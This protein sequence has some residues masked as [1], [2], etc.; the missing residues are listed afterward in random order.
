M[1]WAE[2]R[3]VTLQ[4]RELL[5]IPYL[6]EA[7]AVETEPGQWLIRL[8][9]PELPG[10]TAEGAVVEDALRD[11]ERRRVEIIV[12]LVERDQQPPIPR[13]PLAASD[14]LWTVHELG[15]SDRVTPLLANENS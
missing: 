11:L 7:E 10:C 14:P 8:A 1:P 4:L 3:E 6:L 5:A 2:N 15:L 9:Y 12:G 13:Q